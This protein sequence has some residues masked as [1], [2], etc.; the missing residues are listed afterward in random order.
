MK[1][2]GVLR[3]GGG[4]GGQLAIG[5]GNSGNPATLSVDGG[6]VLIN[7]NNCALNIASGVPGVAG[8]LTLNSGAVSMAAGATVALNVGTQAGDVGKLNL[9]GGTLSIAQLRKDP[10]AFSTNNFNGGTLRAVNANFAGTFMT[11]LD[12][13]NVRN[14]GAVI[15]SGAFAI[16]I[17]QA[18]EH[19]DIGGD[20]ATDGGLTKIGNGVVSLGGAST[21]TGGTTVS[22]GTLL[23]NGS[24]AGSSVAVFN[25]ATLGGAGTVSA[26]VTIGADGTLAPGTGIA[27]LTLASSLALNGKLAVEVDNSALPSSDLCNVT[28]ALSAGAGTVTVTNIG[29]NPLNL[30]DSFTLF[31]KAVLNGGALTI[32][33]VP[34]PGLAWTNKLAF[35]GSIAVVAAPLIASSP[36][37]ITF[38]V[39]G[40]TLSLAWPASHLGW[41]AQS[42]GVSVSVANAWVDIA[43]S[44]LVTNLNFTINP[45]TTNVF[46]RLRH[47]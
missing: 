34:G 35:D 7:A 39:N 16:T 15:D 43:G 9:N 32:T 38:A 42:N 3:H 25:G 41:L 26:P 10:G 45:A 21:Y 12:R 11:G 20:N 22:N 2:G 1:A 44:D 23:V 40:N 46:Y 29:A 17:D 4:G 27:T 24:I 5:A 36:T 33:P 14:G 47:P 8:T 13:A 37:N 19:S 28:G 6:S 30:G 18:F 31:N